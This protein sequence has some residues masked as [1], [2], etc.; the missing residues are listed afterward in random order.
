MRSVRLVEPPDADGVGVFCLTK[1]AKQAFYVFKEIP[2]DIGGR[3]FIVHRLGLGGLYHVRIGQPAEC[4]CECMGFLAHG[5]CQ[6]E[7]ALLAL[8]EHRQIN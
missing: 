3:G 5:H 8:V 2:C 6:H 1:G 7:T 4:S